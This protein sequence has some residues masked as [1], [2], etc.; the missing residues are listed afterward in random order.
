MNSVVRLFLNVAMELPQTQACVRSANYLA[1][2]LSMRVESW[3]ADNAP[4]EACRIVFRNSQQH[5]ATSRVAVR[6][7]ME[8]VITREESEP[9][10]SPKKRNDFGIAHSLTA[11]LVINLLYAYPPASQKAALAVG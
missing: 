8:P 1:H 2:S 11:K 9:L 10:E 3:V 5:E 7:L 4:D 6:G